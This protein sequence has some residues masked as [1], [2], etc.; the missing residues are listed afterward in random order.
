VLDLQTGVHFHKVELVGVGV[1]DEF[2]S[3][4]ANIIDGF[5]GGN[6]FSTKIVAELL[7]KAGL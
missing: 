4:S 3:T 2:D 6:G 1:K 5:G 7:R